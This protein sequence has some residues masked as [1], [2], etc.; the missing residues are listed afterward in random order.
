MILPTTDFF[1]S[2]LKDTVV[3]CASGTGRTV[4]PMASHFRRVA[5]EWTRNWA[6]LHVSRTCAWVSYCCEG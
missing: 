5:A 6:V 2:W 3:L 4:K 1:R